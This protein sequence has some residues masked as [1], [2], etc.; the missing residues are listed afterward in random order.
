MGALPFTAEQFFQVFARYNDA[1]W[2]A[3]VLWWVT[4][5]ALVLTVWRSATTSRWLMGLLA[6]CWLWNA[7]VYHAWLFTAINPAAWGFAGLFLLQAGLLAS[8]CQGAVRPFFRAH[9]WR[10]SLGV[11]LTAYAFLY[12]FLTIAAGHRWP[13]APTFAVPCPTVILTIGLFLTTPAVPAGLTAIPVLWA[14]VGG[15]AAYLLGVPTDYPLLGAGVVL[16]GVT[17]QQRLSFRMRTSPQ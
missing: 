15:S 17:I 14:F 9:G 10:Q 2:P 16:T 3:V 1:L 6:L 4:T 7:V 11:G 12:P 13:A 8:A 5:L